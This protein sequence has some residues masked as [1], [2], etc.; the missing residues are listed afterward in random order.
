MRRTF[1]PAPSDG[2][3]II[4]RQTA[5]NDVCERMW[6]A[7]ALSIS[8][9]TSIGSMR[10]VR[11]YGGNKTT[12]KICKTCAEIFTSTFMLFVSILHSFAQMSKTFYASARIYLMKFQS[13]AY[14][15][16]D[17]NDGPTVDIIAFASFEDKIKLKSSCRHGIHFLIR[18]ESPHRDDCREQNANIWHRF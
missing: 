8:C 2:S 9:V 3:T 17:D 11:F 18:T 1:F 7:V 5:A 4:N 16:F 13:S 15:V 14:F 10:C 6:C 12:A